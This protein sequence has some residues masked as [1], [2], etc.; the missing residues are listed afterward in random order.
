MSEEGNLRSEN[1]MQDIEE[2]DSDHGSET[3]GDE[4]EQ[5]ITPNATSP[6]TGATCV[7]P[8]TSL[9]LQFDQVLTQRVLTYHI[10]WAEDNSGTCRTCLR[11]DIHLPRMISC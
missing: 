6:W 3:S 10:N 1:K 4:A 5:S 7:D 8:T 2:I 9:L 11:Y